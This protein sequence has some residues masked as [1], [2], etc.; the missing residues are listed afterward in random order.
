MWGE[1][2]KNVL[3][4]IEMYTNEQIDK[5]IS[6][7]QTAAT[8]DPTELEEGIAANKEAVEKAQGAAQISGSI[9]RRIALYG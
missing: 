4:I 6:D 1:I 9:F 2:P 3:R 7:A 5:A 8:F